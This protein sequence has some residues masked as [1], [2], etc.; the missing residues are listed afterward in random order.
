MALHVTI[1]SYHTFENRRIFESQLLAK[2]GMGVVWCRHRVVYAACKGASGIGITN[3]DISNR[4]P[5][6]PLGWELSTSTK[7]M[8]LILAAPYLQM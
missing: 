7:V 4:V 3:L 1:N 8:N 6:M 5:F 2:D